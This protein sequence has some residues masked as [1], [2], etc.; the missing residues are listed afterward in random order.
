[1]HNRQSGAAHVPM[2]FF[3]L[4]LVM[5]LGALMYA[6]MS[7]SENGKLK[8]ERDQAR[9]DLQAIK[10]RE[11]LVEHYI[12]DL[13]RVVGKPGKY[14][15]RTGQ[16]ASVYQGATLPYAGVMNPAEIKKVMDDACAAAEVSTAG[17]LE[18]V[19]G[20]L[21]GKVSQQKT[22]V[23]DIEAERDKVVAEKT[24]VDRKFQ[25]ASS[26][27]SKAASEW[28]QNLETTRSTF[29]AATTEQ[30]NRLN[31]VQETLKAKADE[32]TT[33]KEK[34]LAKEKDLNKEIEK[35]KMQ[36]SALTARESLRKAADVADG[37]VLV[38]KSGISTAF[39]NLGRKDM[40]QPGTTFRVRSPNSDTV[41]GYATVKRVEE[42]SAEVELRDFVDPVGDFAREGDLL[43]NDLYTPRMTRTIY[44]M[45][46]FTAPYQK[47]QVAMLLKRL[48]NTVVDKMKPGV[49]T[50]ILGNNPI[51]EAGDGF[52]EVS[53]S[54]EFKLASELRVEFAYLNQVR[55][56]IQL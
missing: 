16:T 46:R 27:A 13:A 45:G 29:T 24:E 31:Q 9:T 19:L 51:N 30:G 20:A 12:E 44:L 5:F 21:I 40:L 11:L 34:A 43:Y 38:A 3:L 10:G 32:L 28:N 26:S 47:E 7:V 25:E 14:E 17:S 42:E 53:E 2:I 39:I 52:T 36:H 49:D 1:M 18:N 8:L 37:K 50:V 22:R 35:H 48:G 55:D 4:L 54:E 15:G 23:R 41:K 56:L 33:E 6:Y